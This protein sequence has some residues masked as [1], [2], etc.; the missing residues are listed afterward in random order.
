MT[1]QSPGA[2]NLLRKCMN[3]AQRAFVATSIVGTLWVCVNVG[4]FAFQSSQKRKRLA[5]EGQVL[6]D[7][8]HHHDGDKTK[9]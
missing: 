7:S 2:V 1:L 4:I 9:Q 3:F 5:Q 6:P 8:S